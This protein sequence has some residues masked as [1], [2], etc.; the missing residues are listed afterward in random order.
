MRRKKTEEEN[1][2]NPKRE[3][4][5]CLDYGDKFETTIIRKRQT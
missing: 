4:M 3:T 2:S 5:T 1:K